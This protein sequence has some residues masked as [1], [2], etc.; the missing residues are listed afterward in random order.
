MNSYK[1]L[2][3]GVDSDLNIALYNYLPVTIF[4]LYIVAMTGKISVA[5]GDSGIMTNT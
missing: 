5:A 4:N 3:L 2:L 1:Y